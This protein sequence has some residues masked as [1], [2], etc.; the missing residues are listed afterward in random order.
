MDVKFS[1][2]YVDQDVYY[3]AF[4]GKVRKLEADTESVI[5]EFNESIYFPVGGKIMSIIDGKDYSDKG[6][7]TVDKYFIF[8]KGI[9]SFNTLR[10]KYQRHPVGVTTKYKNITEDN[11]TDVLLN[12]GFLKH[13]LKED[14]YLYVGLHTSHVVMISDR[15]YIYKM[16]VDNT[17][18][19]SIQ[20]D[21]L[22]ELV[23]FIEARTKLNKV[24]DYLPFKSW[25]SNF[26]QCNNIEN[27]DVDFDAQLSS[28]IPDQ[29][30]YTELVGN[31]Q[32]NNKPLEIRGR[33]LDSWTN[34]FKARYCI[35]VCTNIIK[36][37]KLRD[38]KE[39]VNVTKFS[40]E[41]I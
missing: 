38:E 2:F 6:I 17:T 23:K 29:N 22:K 12:S 18:V 25:W 24:V 3:Q 31:V 36:T 39:E 8:N 13:N 32:V 40:K 4:K 14:T 34:N 11:I 7:R 10:F 16:I 15:M 28:V 37:F 21:N 33:I 41:P 1:D 20:T 30:R 27:F 19:N 35:F 5:I 9:K 26:K